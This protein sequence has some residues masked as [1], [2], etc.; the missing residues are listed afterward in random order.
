MSKDLTLIYAV[1]GDDNHYL[2]LQKAL[3]SHERLLEQPKTIIIDCHNKADNFI[4]T[5]DRVSIVKYEGKVPTDKSQKHLFWRMR[6]DAYKYIDTEYGMYADVDTVF[7]N[8]TL[9]N[10]LP[11]IDGFG[12]CKH[13]WVPTFQDYYEKA[14]GPSYYDLLFKTFGIDPNAHYIASGAFIWKWKY[15][16]ILKEVV[17][18]FNWFYNF[19][20]SNYVEHITDEVWLGRSLYHIGYKNLTLLNGAFN[21]CIE[22]PMPIEIRNNK[23]CYGKNPNEKYHYPITLGH[24]DTF[25]RNP[26]WQYGPEINEICRKQFYL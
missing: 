25:R 20:N 15:S 8:D 13:F 12:I 7:F 5:D 3:R 10:L 19:G 18:F 14:A 23:E 4:K 17:D 21:H 26:G 16:H 9:G 22:P 11:F 1:G 6:Y 24:C 2:N